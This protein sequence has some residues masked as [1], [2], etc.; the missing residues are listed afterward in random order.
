LPSAL[1]V[2]APLDVEA[3]RRW[4]DDPS[5]GSGPQVFADPQAPQLTAMQR[6]SAEHWE[7]ASPLPFAPT[8]RALG[9]EDRK[10]ALLV[11]HDPERASIRR[12]LCEDKPAAWDPHALAGLCPVTPPP[13]LPPRAATATPAPPGS[14]QFGPSLPPPPPEKFFAPINADAFVQAHAEACAK[15]TAAQPCAAAIQARRML[16][17]GASLGRTREL[18]AAAPFPHVAP[19]DPTL[20]ESATALFDTGIIRQ[21]PVGEA[22]HFCTPFVAEASSGISFTDTES[23]AP[24]IAGALAA[25]LRV[26]HA[27]ASAYAAAVAPQG[28]SADHA[29]RERAASTAWAQASEAAVPNDK[30]RFVLD[31]DELNEASTAARFAYSSV[32]ELLPFLFEGYVITKADL[33]KG[34]YQIPLR[35]EDIPYTAFLVRDAQGLVYCFAFQRLVMGAKGSALSFSF[36][37]AMLFEMMMHACPSAVKAIIYLDD[38]ITIW[39][40]RQDALQGIAI[41]RALGKRTGV[42]FS[43]SKT[44]TEGKAAELCLGALL[45]IPAR[46]ATMPPAKHAALIASAHAVRTICSLGLAIPRRALNTLGGRA[47]MLAQLDK[48]AASRLRPLTAWRHSGQTSRSLFRWKE[49]DVGPTLAACDYIIDRARGGQP[50]GCSLRAAGGPPPRVLYSMSDASG[51][52]NTVAVYT[53]APSMVVCHF[54]DCGG[55]HTGTLEA[56]ALLLIALRYGPLLRDVRVR[57]ALDSI[58]VVFAAASGRSREPTLNEVVGLSALAAQAFGFEHSVAWLSRWLNFLCDRSAAENPFVQRFPGFDP[59]GVTQV[60][61]YPGCPPTALVELAASLDPSWRWSSEWGVNKR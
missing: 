46:T 3:V 44:S 1:A 8:A 14:M 48:A 57:Q 5:A 32:K 58:S 55:V 29:V 11:S 36:I 53:S 10:A 47:N 19:Y 13:P 30:R 43:D 2:L 60:L 16:T 39:R 24:P 20:W 56:I 15:C 59:A 45:D 41:L 22:R 31:P 18:P 49:G 28:A 50:P 7:G 40:S 4:R 38:L 12:T 35:E 54:P 37:T 42:Q 21:L 23:A 34:Y 26:G 61:T 17:E 27:I 52:S 33:A 51:P 25:G 6:R 9:S